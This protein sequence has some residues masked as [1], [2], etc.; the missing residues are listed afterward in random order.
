LSRALT[1]AVVSGKGG[2]GKTMLS[3]AIANEMARGHRTLLLDLDFFNR[4][5]T[6]LFATAVAHSPC[7]PVAAPEGLIGTVEAGDWLIANVHPNLFVLSF[8]DVAKSTS[9]ALEAMDIQELALRLGA[10]VAD[11]CEAAQC[12]VAILDC[13]GGPDNMSFA[14]CM[15]AQHSILVSEPDKITLYG[16]LNFLRTLAG[17]GADPR[18]DIRLVFNKVIPAFNARFLLRFYDTY[19]AREFA[20]HRL[21]AIYPIEPYLTKAFEKTPFLTTV[22]PTSQLAVKTRLLLYELLHREA[23]ELLPQAFRHP[24]R[25]VVWYRRYSMGRRPRVLELDFIFQ[26]MAITVTLLLS[27]PWLAARINRIAA[28]PLAASLMFSDQTKSIILGALVIWMLIAVYVK[29]LHDLDVFT[30]FSWRT[31]ARAGAIAGGLVL[32]LLCAGSGLTASSLIR[33]E[34]H[35]HKDASMS[36]IRI[37][38][39]II[40]LLPLLGQAW[41]GVRNIRLDRR[42][43]EGGCRIGLAAVPVALGLVDVILAR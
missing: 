14:A 24:R 43:L 42:L 18:P 23:P 40:L 32:L 28:H 8:G 38:L 21:L 20:S 10:Y 22:Y 1:I 37:A 5:L 39:S 36:A 27:I 15:V 7:Q 31:H 26:I 41:R 34:L 4:G 29:W 11:L 30:T 6:G 17:M 2:V 3:V 25:I 12:E 9:T 33:A 13:H 16:T 19:L 35:Q